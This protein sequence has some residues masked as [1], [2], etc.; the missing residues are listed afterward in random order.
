M[1]FHWTFNPFTFSVVMDKYVFIAILLIVLNCYF[2]YFILSFV[3]CSCDCQT[4]FSV[5][6]GLLFPFYVCVYYCF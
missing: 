4:I 6:F 2:G 3:V 1:S 5:V